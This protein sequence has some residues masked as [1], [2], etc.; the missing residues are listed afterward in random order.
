METTPKFGMGRAIFWSATWA[1]GAALGVALGGWLT[2]VGGVGAPG[3]EAMDLGTDVLLLPSLS[4]LTV[5]V[6]HFGGQIIF[7]S[8]RSR[9]PVDSPCDGGESDKDQE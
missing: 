3:V 6:V 1:L 4:G 9:T 2:A 7:A 5:L 8:F